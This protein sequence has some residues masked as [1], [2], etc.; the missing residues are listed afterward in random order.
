MTDPAPVVAATTTSNLTIVSPLSA[1]VL[2]EV[3]TAQAAVQSATTEMT[4]AQAQATAAAAVVKSA[5]SDLAAA[6]KRH[7]AA[8]SMLHAANLSA[9]VEQT[10]VA[11]VQAFIAKHPVEAYVLVGFL[12]AVLGA[13]VG[14]SF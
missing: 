13:A 4:K 12:A 9:G 8:V 6:T 3:N 10:A 1:S 2:T 5:K 11:K 14:Y 7:N